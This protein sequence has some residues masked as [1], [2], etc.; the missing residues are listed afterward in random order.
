MLKLTPAQNSIVKRLLADALTDQPTGIE[1]RPLDQRTVDGLL[2]RGIATVRAGQLVLTAP[3]RTVWTSSG[4]R[5][6]L[7]VAS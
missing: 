7:D 1:V 3:T 4:A 6:R 5:L 2:R